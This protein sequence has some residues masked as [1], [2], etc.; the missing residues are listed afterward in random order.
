[1][2][3]IKHGGKP[4]AKSLVRDEIAFSITVPMSILSAECQLASH[5]D[6]AELAALE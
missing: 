4:I 2:N 1:M 5:K 6:H 3:G